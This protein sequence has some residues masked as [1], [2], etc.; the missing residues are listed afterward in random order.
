VLAVNRVV[1]FAVQAI[2]KERRWDNR[3]WLRTK[4]CHQVELGE[5]CWRLGKR[6]VFALPLEGKEAE[7][8]VLLDRPAN[9]TAKPLP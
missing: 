5:S 8:L 3:C 6:S 7:E 1:K 9:R 2:F 4:A